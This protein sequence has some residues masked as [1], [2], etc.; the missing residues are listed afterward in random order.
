MNAVKRAEDRLLER[1]VQKYRD[2]RKANNTRSMLN[3]SEY[4]E[5]IHETHTSFLDEDDLSA[6]DMRRISEYLNA[7][8]L[9]MYSQ[10][11][12]VHELHRKLHDAIKPRHVKTYS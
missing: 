10:S 9:S 8:R 5:A 2:V 1:I 4:L 3:V 11:S 6:Q 7:L 12:P